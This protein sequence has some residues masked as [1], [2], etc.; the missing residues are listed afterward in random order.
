M[1]SLEQRVIVAT[2]LN[3]PRGKACA[4]VEKMVEESGEGEKAIAF[5]SE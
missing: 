5:S 4:E 1:D 3:F 2:Q